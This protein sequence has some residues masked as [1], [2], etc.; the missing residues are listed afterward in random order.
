RPHGLPPLRRA[1]VTDRLGRRRECLQDLDPGPREASRHAL[2]P[3]RGPN[4]RLPPRAAALRT[5]GSLLV[6]PPTTPSTARRPTPA[7][8]HLDRR[9]DHSCRLTSQLW[10]GPP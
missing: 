1:P 2:E 9:V 10:G 8:L 7:A 3:E 6:L 4:R 5:L